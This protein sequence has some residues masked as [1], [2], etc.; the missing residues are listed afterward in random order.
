MAMLPTVVQ[1]HPTMPT[2]I[3]IL[4]RIEGHSEA[5]VCSPWPR[6]FLFLFMIYGVEILV[7]LISHRPPLTCLLATCHLPGSLVPWFPGAGGKEQEQ[8]QR[9]RCI[10]H[11]V[12]CS[13]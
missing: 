4:A 6:Q 1:L 12:S 10:A 8:L 11:F 7:L 2:G 13:R 5:G 9:L 3:L